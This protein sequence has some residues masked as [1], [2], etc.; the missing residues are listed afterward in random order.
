ML[1]SKKEK[2]SEKEQICITH[3]L[4]WKIFFIASVF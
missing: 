1:S 4:N 2:I 3:Y